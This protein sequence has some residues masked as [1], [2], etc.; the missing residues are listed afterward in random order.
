MINRAPDG[1]IAPLHVAVALQGHRDGAVTLRFGSFCF[2]GLCVPPPRPET[3]KDCPLWKQ[4]QGIYE[5]KFVSKATWEQ[6]RASHVAVEWFSIVWFPQ[7]LPRQAFITWL[8]CRNRL[9]TRDRMRQWGQTKICMLC[10]EPDE[11]RDHLFFAC[12][13][14]Y[15]VWTMLMNLFLAGRINPDRSRTA[16]SIRNNRLTKLD[17]QLVQLAFQA[18]IYW[19]CSE[20]NGR[21]HL[22][23]P[24]SAKYIAMTVHREM[25]NRLMALK[26]GS[27]DEAT[28]EGLSRW[29]TKTAL[30]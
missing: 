3:G 9:D 27:G 20:R 18:S 24:H 5:E 14:T 23:P 17:A 4:S 10:G 12:P 11:T 19:I 28:N 6:S 30:P 15:T 2:S 29:N 1:G 26:Y 13:F 16:A 8:A 22:H 25:Q 7:A 21:R